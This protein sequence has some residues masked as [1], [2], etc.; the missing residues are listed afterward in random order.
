[1]SVIAKGAFES[2]AGIW[3]RFGPTIDHAEWAGHHA[4]PA[5]VAH[6]VLHE[7][8]ADLGPHDRAGWTRLKTTGFFA[9]FANIRKE[10]PAEWIFSIAAA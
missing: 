1:M 5:A 6:I 8:G 7:N 3:Q 2:A 9:V 4:I 10:N